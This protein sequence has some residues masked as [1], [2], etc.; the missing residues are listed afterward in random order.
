MVAAAM[1]AEASKIVEAPPVY[2][3]RS[4]RSRESAGALIGLARKAL[5]REY[6]RALEPLG[7]NTVQALAIVLLAEGCCGTAADIGRELS[8]DAGAMTRMIDKL[9]TA[10]LVRRVPRERDR[11]AA[12]LELTKEGRRVHEEVKRVQVTLLNRMLRGFSKTEARTLEKLLKR[13]LENANQ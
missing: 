9:E 6:D 10:G 5:V 4:F 3:L 12:D 13:L 2:E 11:R 7:L 1:V 8:H